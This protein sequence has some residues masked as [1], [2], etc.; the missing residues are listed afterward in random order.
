MVSAWNLFISKYSSDPD[1]A[2]KWIEYHGDSERSK[3]FMEDFGIDLH[4][5]QHMKIKLY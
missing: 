2:W 3:Q 4:I 1:S 5:E